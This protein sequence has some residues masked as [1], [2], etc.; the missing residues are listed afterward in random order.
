V[1]FYFVKQDFSSHCLKEHD[2]LCSKFS[3]LQLSVSVKGIKVK[4][5]H[6]ENEILSVCYNQPAVHD[7]FNSK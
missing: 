6:T 3:G 5:F 7:E 4:K 1:A 2:S